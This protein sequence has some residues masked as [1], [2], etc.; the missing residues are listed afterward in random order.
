MRHRVVPTKAERWQQLIDG[1]CLRSR[2][3]KGNDAG[4]N[5]SAY[6]ATV[7]IK[8]AVRIV[9]C[10][11]VHRPH[12]LDRHSSG[13]LEPE[14][15]RAR[16]N[17]VKSGVAQWQRGSI[18]RFRAAIALPLRTSSRQN[19]QRDSLFVFS[20]TRALLFLVKKIFGRDE[21]KI[22]NKF[23]FFLSILKAIS[24]LKPAGERETRTHVNKL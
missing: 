14:K 5:N 10:L 2:K 22:S 21:N 20:R 17:S 9:L 1:I 6:C 3:K 24:S 16:V 11:R 13:T 18:D 12:F 15:L 7:P 8:G 4:R 19:Q 23:I